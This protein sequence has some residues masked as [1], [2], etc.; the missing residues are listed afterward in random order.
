MGETLIRVGEILLGLVSFTALST[1]WEWCRTTKRLREHVRS[2]VKAVEFKWKNQT[3]EFA[4]MH[5]IRAYEV[6]LRRV[7]ALQPR[8]PFAYRRMEEV[9]DALEFLHMATPVFQGKHLPLARI[10]EFPIKHVDSTSRPKLSS[11]AWVRQKILERLRA[12]TWLKLE[13]PDD[14]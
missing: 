1:L 12:I 14:Q 9:R 11:E 8:T 5:R 4:T 7:Q 13:E 2:Y 10:G 6:L 3:E